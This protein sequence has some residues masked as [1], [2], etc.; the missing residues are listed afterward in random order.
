M[1]EVTSLLGTSFAFSV[2][3]RYVFPLLMIG[4]AALVVAV[5]SLALWH[6]DERYDAVAKRTV[7]IFGAGC[8]IG[9][10]P[11][12]ITGLASAIGISTLT[13][14]LAGR[15]F[16]IEGTVAMLLEATFI[17]LLVFGERRLGRTALWVISVHVL[18]GTW[19][20]SSVLTA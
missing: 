3:M 20:M 14:P 11:A 17:C 9:L 19:V 5:R 8:L 18:V 10:L 2:A 6:D 7:T 13:S 12:M 15:A 4:I 1:N 16:T